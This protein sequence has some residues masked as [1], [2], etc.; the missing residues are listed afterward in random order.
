MTLKEY[1]QLKKYID[2]IILK[3]E[4]EAL[5]EGMDITSDEYLNGIEEI[6]KNI[7][8]QK[9]ISYDAY[10]DFEKGLK[11]GNELSESDVLV[12]P[13]LAKRMKE[14]TAKKEAEINEKIDNIVNDF[15]ENIN[16][17]K[18][19][20]STKTGSEKEEIL[21]IV[22]R[23]NQKR[24]KNDKQKDGKIK[25][26]EDKLIRKD[27]RD[28]TELYELREEIKKIYSKMPKTV[29][30]KDGKDGKLDENDLKRLR[31]ERKKEITKTIKEYSGNWYQLPMLGLRRALQKQVDAIGTL[32]IDLS[33]QLD[34][35][36]TEFTLGR[37]VRAVIMANLNG[38]IVPH[39]LNTGKNKVTLAFAPDTGEELSVIT[40]I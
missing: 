28:D 2:K 32:E 35:S 11:E 16:Q 26:L 10:I 6:V 33:S 15:A 25:E 27:I 7:L 3:L 9:G 19:E 23:E 13:A 40:L 30:G 22:K 31:A 20:L 4:E 14:N 1:Q 12:F 8:S 21:N 5:N 38:T 24:D 39:T 18:G 37:T 17:L 29:D 34:G 36:E